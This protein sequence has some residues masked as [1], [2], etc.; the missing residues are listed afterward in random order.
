MKKERDKIIPA[1]EYKLVNPENVSV[2]ERNDLIA[3]LTFLPTTGNAYCNFI[4]ARVC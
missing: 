4:P 1:V 3:L 2:R